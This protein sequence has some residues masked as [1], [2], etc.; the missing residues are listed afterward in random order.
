MSFAWQGDFPAHVLFFAPL[1][2]GIRNGATP[3]A[4]GPRHCGQ[5]RKNSLLEIPP[6][7]TTVTAVVPSSNGRTRAMVAATSANQRIRQGALRQL[8]LR[9]RTMDCRCEVRHGDRPDNI[10]CVFR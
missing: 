10:F 7:A 9:L 5:E 3:L 1:D 2:R 4:S 6:P 8:D